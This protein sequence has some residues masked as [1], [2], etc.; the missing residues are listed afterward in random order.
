[1]SAPVERSRVSIFACGERVRGDDGVAAAAVRA[2]PRPIRALAEVR[3]VA[4]LQPEDLICLPAGQGVLIVDAVVGP[5]PGDLVRLDLDA[6]AFRAV[7]LRP[8]SSHQLPLAMVVGLAE[9]IGGHHPGV[10][11]GLAA[12]SFEVGARLSDP[13]RH[14]LPALRQAICD[15]VRQLDERARLHR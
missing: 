3:R 7:P 6:L 8:G 1:V 11:L 5:E 12:C 15:E 14:G 9:A 2:L 13:V 4:A 10:F